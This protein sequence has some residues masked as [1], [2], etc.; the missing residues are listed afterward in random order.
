MSYAIKS[1]R[2]TDAKASDFGNDNIF[3]TALS[4]SSILVALCFLA[5]FDTNFWYFPVD[6]LFGV[7]WFAVFALFIVRFNKT[8]CKPGVGQI[9]TL[10][11]GGECNLQR[12]AWGFSFLSGC[13]WIAGSII[14]CWVVSREKQLKSRRKTTIT[15]I[16]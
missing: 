14:G 2:K 16:G 4:A 5:P 9:K 1:L 7:A 3:A 8:E 12:C 13:V 6:F 15:T 10:A 11:L